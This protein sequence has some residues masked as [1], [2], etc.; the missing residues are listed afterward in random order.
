MLSF[1][2]LLWYFTQKS[3]LNILDKSQ[4]ISANIQASV[5]AL[6][7]QIFTYEWVFMFT[8]NKKVEQI[9]YVRL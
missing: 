4:K 9:Y 5:W 6:L 7:L 2:I 8:K 1:I 3:L